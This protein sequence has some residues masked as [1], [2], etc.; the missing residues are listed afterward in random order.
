MLWRVFLPWGSYMH[1]TWVFEDPYLLLSTGRDFI[2]VEHWVVNFKLLSCNLSDYFLECHL[3]FSLW[4]LPIGFLLPACD[5]KRSH[6][7]V[8]SVSW[9][10]C[11]SVVNR[12][13]C[14]AWVY[15]AKYYNDGRWVSADTFTS[16]LLDSRITLVV[17]LTSGQMLLVVVK[18]SVQQDRIVLQVS[19][20]FH[21]VVGND[22]FA[23]SCSTC[24][25]LTLSIVVSCFW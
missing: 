14:Y 5:A 13:S 20:K 7:H 12:I 15:G 4:S 23:Q 24:L 19:K 17:Q 9:Y 21:A 2:C 1:D 3:N 10:C 6:W 25:C 8:W 22:F 11:C 18:Y 16:Y